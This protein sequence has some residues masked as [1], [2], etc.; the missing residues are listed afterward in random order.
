L[1]GRAN[2]WPNASTVF[3]TAR[4]LAHNSHLCVP[5]A[6]AID[7]ATAAAYKLRTA[8]TRNYVNAFALNDHMV[9]D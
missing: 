4:G 2:E 9:Y 3:F 7:Y 5:D 6:T 8:I 1:T